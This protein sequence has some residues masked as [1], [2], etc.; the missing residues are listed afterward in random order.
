MPDTVSHRLLLLNLAQM[1]AAACMTLVM[2]CAGHG[3]HNLPRH[4]FL[5][6][7]VQR[8]TLLGIRK[9]VV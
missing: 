8:G 9:Y 6:A 2:F 1:L 4:T 7:P 5:L 3:W